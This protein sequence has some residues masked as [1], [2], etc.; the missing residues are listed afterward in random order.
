MGQVYRKRGTIEVLFQSFKSR[1]FHLKN[2]HMQALLK[3]K[4]L[5]GLVSIAFAICNSL[6]IYHHQKV[7]KIEVKNHGYKAK[8]FCRT[9]IDLLRDMLKGSVKEFEEVTQKFLRYLTILKV[10]YHKNKLSTSL[11]VT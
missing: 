2:T 6:G 9:G 4:K 1:G 5:V 8:S 11:S 10:N 7:Q 3:L